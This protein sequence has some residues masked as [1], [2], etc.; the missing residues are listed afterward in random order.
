MDIDV[1]PVHRDPAWQTSVKTRIVARQQQVVRVDRERAGTMSAGSLERFSAELGRIVPQVDGIIVADYAKGTIRQALADEIC[2]LARKH[3]KLLA[4]DPSPKN[5]IEWQNVS[6]IKP[7]RLE[8]FLAAGRMAQ[9][10]DGSDRDPAVL[11]EVGERLLGKWNAEM[12][13]LTLG[14]EGMMLFERG[15]P[16]YHTPTRAREIFD[17][18]GAGDTAIATLALA[19]TCGAS[20]TEAAEIANAA[21]GIVVGK[22]GTAAVTPTDLAE[23][24][25]AR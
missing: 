9:K 24:F 6:V 22:L 5:P 17:V 4:V 19:L 2:A 18:S 8:A 23:A 21:A 11:R 1:S 13:L 20:P 15:R 14:E 3:G 12:L 7:N 25:E 10:D 16:P